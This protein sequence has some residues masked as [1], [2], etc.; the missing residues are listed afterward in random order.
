[1]L[2]KYSNINTKKKS[3]YLKVPEPP[4]PKPVEE[5]EVPTVTK[6]ERKIPE[7]TKGT[8]LLAFLVVSKNANMYH[9]KYCYTDI[10]I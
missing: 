2:L 1:M 4:P 9:L 5:V 7:P 8:N 3:Y 6:R 10:K